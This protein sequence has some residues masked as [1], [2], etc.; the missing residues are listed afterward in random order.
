MFCRTSG[1]NHF[2]A[3]E[4]RQT[5]NRYKKMSRLSDAMEKKVKAYL[6]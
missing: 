1:Q 2:N 3:K 6:Q 4:S 5:Q